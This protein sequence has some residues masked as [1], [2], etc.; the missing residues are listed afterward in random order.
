MIAHQKRYI[1][2]SSSDN[3][4]KTIEFLFDIELWYQKKEGKTTL[5]MS[6]KLISRIPRIHLEEKLGSDTVRLLEQL[7]YK[8]LKSSHLAKII[9]KIFGD[10]VLLS[11]NKLR[12][13]MLSAMGINEAKELT[14]K[15][16][17]KNVDTFKFL[18]S[19][20]FK[21]SLNKNK[22][23]KWLKLE[24]RILNSSFE[25]NEL[26][27]PKVKTINPTYGLFPHQINA[28]KKIMNF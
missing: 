7:D 12:S 15:F 23:A 10:D 14:K 5:L 18:K 20:N 8:S 21:Q 1:A 24:P 26:L 4:L 27:E 6:E 22:L 9:L 25:T 28:I 2:A 19:I 3:S 11:D 16:T 13:N 17:S